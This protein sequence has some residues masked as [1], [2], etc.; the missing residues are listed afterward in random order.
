[1]STAAAHAAAFFRDAVRT[2][3]V[4]TVRDASGF[5]APLLPGGRRAMPFWS[6]PGRVRRVIARV[7]AYASFE[8]V[9]IPLDEFRRA[10]LPGLERDRT[11]VG[12]NCSGDRAT[13]YDYE[14]RDVTARLDSEPPHD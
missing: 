7:P 6:T 13:G 3:R 10:W 14:P 4:W 12:L 2:G 8:P 11:L 9:E 1:M 5:P